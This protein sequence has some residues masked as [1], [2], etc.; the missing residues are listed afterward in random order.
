MSTASPLSTLTQKN[1]KLELLE[2]FEKSLQVLKDRLNSAH[3][4]ILA[5]GINFFVVYC[6]ESLIGFDCV[7]MQL[8]KI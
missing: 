7:L 5:E 1:V 3:V 6:D 8:G 4:L 2:A